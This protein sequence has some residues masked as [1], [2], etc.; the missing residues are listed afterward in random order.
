MPHYYLI[1]QEA[2]C[3]RHAGYL[4]SWM[5][6]TLPGACIHTHTPDTFL[7][8]PVQFTGQAGSPA[9]CDA[10]GM[11][12]EQTASPGAQGHCAMV[13]EHDRFSHTLLAG[14]TVYNT[15]LACG[16]ERVQ[17]CVCILRSI[18][19]YP[20]EALGTNSQFTYR[21]LWNSAPLVWATIHVSALQYL[22]HANSLWLIISQKS[23][24][25][26]VQDS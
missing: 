5:R 24:P 14:D 9:H 1:E 13:H 20:P 8:N 4:L 7:E 26:L 3:E 25:C 23:L 10:H 15:L 22:L 11:G 19:N 2:T 16:T 17:V 6:V 21:R 18:L 12:S